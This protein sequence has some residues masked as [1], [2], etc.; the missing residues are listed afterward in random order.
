MTTALVARMYWLMRHQATV[1][2][3][4]NT[5][6]G[7]QYLSPNPAS[8]IPEHLQAAVDGLVSQLERSVMLQVKNIT[9]LKCVE[10]SHCGVNSPNVFLGNTVARQAW[11]SSSPVESILQCWPFSRIGKPWVPSFV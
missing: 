4:N 1:P 3:V 9:S 5:T 10:P 6:P 7:D 2:R 11:Q 8:G